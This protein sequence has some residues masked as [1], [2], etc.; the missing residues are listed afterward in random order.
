ML[1]FLC[2]LT[3]LQCYLL[4]TGKLHLVD[5]TCV[6]SFADDLEYW[7]VDELYMEGCCQHRYHHLKVSFFEAVYWFLV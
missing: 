2:V 5:D 6:L 1:K 7:G 4:F 3:S